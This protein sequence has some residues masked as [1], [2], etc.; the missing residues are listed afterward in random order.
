MSS[1]VCPHF[2]QLSETLILHLWTDCPRRRACI[3]TQIVHQARY[4]TFQ[5]KGIHLLDDE[6]PDMF[7]WMGELNLHKEALRGNGHSPASID[8]IDR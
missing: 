1:S 3:L 6:Y 8:D 2:Q 4:V 5:A 7:Q